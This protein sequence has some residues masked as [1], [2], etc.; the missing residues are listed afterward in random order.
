MNYKEIVREYIEAFFPDCAGALL[1]GSA[2]NGE[3]T[4]QS[5]LDVI[6]LYED[7]HRHYRKIDF[8]RD[9]KIE[10]MVHRISE[11][12]TMFESDRLKRNR[13]FLDLISK[14][15]IVKDT[16]TLVSQLQLN[17]KHIYEQNPIPFTLYEKKL[18]HY[19][20]KNRLDDFEAKND[21]SESYFILSN[22][23]YYTTK[24]LLV[25]NKQWSNKTDGKWQLRAIR[26]FNPELASRFTMA[27]ESFCKQN[28]KTGIAMLVREVMTSLV[29]DSSYHYEAGIPPKF[30]RSRKWMVI[31]VYYAEPQNELLAELFVAMVQYIREKGWAENVFFSRDCRNGAH[32]RLHLGTEDLTIKEQVIAWAEVEASR[33]LS[34]NP[35]LRILADTHKQ[36]PKRFQLFPNNSL[37]YH[38]FEVDIL[39]YMGRDGL[40][41]LEHQW[42]ASSDFVL[43]LLASNTQRDFNSEL[44]YVLKV[45]WDMLLALDLTAAE[46]NLFCQGY[47]KSWSDFEF[48]VNMPTFLF[49]DQVNI[50]AIGAEHQIKM[51]KIFDN[52]IN[53][54]AA[55]MESLLP[56][57]TNTN[58]TAE[59]LVFFTALCDNKRK[60]KCL[61]NEHR[62]FLPQGVHQDTS[63]ITN[64]DQPCWMFYKEFI[65]TLINQFGLLHRNELYVM[66]A[67]AQNSKR[68]VEET[69]CIKA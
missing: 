32:L 7:V 56:M 37:Q 11:C 28:D 41:V 60:L 14:G 65:H 22:V 9:Q 45:V 44:D 16:D 26:K 64:S 6:V 31:D 52:N 43:S 40:L 67:I 12:F 34:H 27:I 15:V 46:I 58:K 49:S 4:P 51:M 53:D 24:I 29:E 30:N 18:Y 5:D 38:H 47:W 36:L 35:S 59:E 42:S 62:L 2:V 1:S 57:Q 39:K 48:S 23:L 10:V 19:I 68:L 54:N 55:Q 33:Y 66:Y 63:G 25:Q 21:F 20:L 50:E 17:A 69:T 8:Y 61:L 3:M 13:S